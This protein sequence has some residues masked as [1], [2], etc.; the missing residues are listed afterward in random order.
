M[1]R[2]IGRAAGNAFRFAEYNKNPKNVGQYLKMKK[3]EI[4]TEK[5]HENKESLEELQGAHRLLY[6]QYAPAIFFAFPLLYLIND[7]TDILFYQCTNLV[8]YYLSGLLCFN[9]FFTQSTFPDM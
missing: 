1:I 4:L 9:S 6:L 2:I 8:Q 3:G 7:P 5:L